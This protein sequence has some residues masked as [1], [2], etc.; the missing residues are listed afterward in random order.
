MSTVVALVLVVAEDI[1]VK[2]PHYAFCMTLDPNGWEWLAY[3]CFVYDNASNMTAAIVSTAVAVTAAKL[4]RW[5]AGH[6]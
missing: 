1:I 5:F 3:G 6:R 4:M 2:N